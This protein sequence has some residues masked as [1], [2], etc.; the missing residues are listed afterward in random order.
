MSKNVFYFSL[1]RKNS[2]ERRDWGEKERENTLDKSMDFLEND[3][4]LLN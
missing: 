3:V 4:T 2:P 1:I